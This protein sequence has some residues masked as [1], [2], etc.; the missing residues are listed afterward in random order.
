M[1]FHTIKIT[2]GF[3][4][5][6]TLASIAILAVVIVGPL[7][8][9]SS[10][11]AYARQTKDVMTATYLAEEGLELIQNQY[12]SLYVYCKKNP[13][14][15]DPGSL[16]ESTG[17]ETTTGETTWRVFKQRFGGEGGQPSCYKNNVT[18]TA[19]ENADGCAYDITSMMG[20]ISPTQPVRYLG[21]DVACA[22]L[23]KISK[24]ITGSQVAGGGNNHAE[25][26]KSTYVCSG[27]PLATEP[28]VTAD[29]ARTFKRTVSIEEIP[30]FESSPTYTRYTR[31][32]DDLRVTSEVD[33]RGVNGRAQSLKV[34][35]FMHPRP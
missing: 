3:T 24:T 17:T 9:I 28:G 6:E 10:S 7:A 12:D 30:T 34:V 33:F 19:V 31:Y 8:V 14:A 15:T 32:H 13:T 25:V 22:Y 27:S 16:C 21:T 11:S 35:R 1:K 29:T 20:D 5:L 4:L 23:V 18:N 26:K 2:Q